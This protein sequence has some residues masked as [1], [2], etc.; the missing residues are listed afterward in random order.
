MNIIIM[1]IYTFYKKDKNIFVNSFIKN[2]SKK[3]IYFGSVPNEVSE[4]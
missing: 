3:A 4:I 1:Y 2:L